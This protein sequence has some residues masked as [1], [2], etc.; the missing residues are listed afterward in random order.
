MV[1][2]RKST[3]TR[4]TEYAL[5]KFVKKQINHCNRYKNEVIRMVQAS[6]VKTSPSEQVNLENMPEYS[7]IKQTFKGEQSKLRATFQPVL[8]E[9]Q[10]DFY[11]CKEQLFNGDLTY[12]QYKTK[13]HKIK[14]VLEKRVRGIHQKFTRKKEECTQKKE[15]TIKLSHAAKIKLARH[16]KHNLKAK[17]IWGIIAYLVVVVGEITMNASAFMLMENLLYATITSV[18]FSAVMIISGIGVGNL[19]TNT[20]M[21]KEK[22]KMALI[23]ITVIII[24]VL[25]GVSVMRSQYIAVRPRQQ[26]VSVSPLLFLAIN[27]LFVLSCLF[28]KLF[29][30]PKPQEIEDN[31]NYNHVDREVKGLQKQI[32]SLNT[33]LDSIDKEKEKEISTLEKQEQQKQNLL[34][35]KFQ[36]Y[37]Q[38]YNESCAAYNKLL[39]ACLLYT[40]PSPRDA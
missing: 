7:N 16:V 13:I 27:I 25:W 19:L 32:K 26:H 11:S 1:K 21:D 35:Q 37:V 4:E 12:K 30:L 9:R 14:E 36:R 10:S 28:I 22:R 2:K 3:H 8:E 20:T 24:A 29:I 23:A 18:S 40:S 38:E 34:T 39:S 17:Y 33:T 6:A 31:N 15:E 5:E